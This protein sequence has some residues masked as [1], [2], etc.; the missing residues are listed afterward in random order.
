MMI[1]L[2]KIISTCNLIMQLMNTLLMNIRIS[3]N[4]PA[5]SAI[6][7]S[8]LPQDLALTISHPIQIVS[9]NVTRDSSTRYR[10][11]IILLR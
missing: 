7:Q 9:E 5:M 3:I 8:L 6:S 11:H 10:E 4:D 1:K 2:K